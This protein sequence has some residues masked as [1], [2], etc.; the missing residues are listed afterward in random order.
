MPKRT[1]RNTG[2]KPRPKDFV[3]FVMIT[4]FS[5]ADKLRRIAQAL[6]LK[7]D[8]NLDL[9][10][11]DYSGYLHGNNSPAGVPEAVHGSAA[12]ILNDIVA[13]FPG[14]Y[15]TIKNGVLLIARDQ[16]VKLTP[17][18]T[19]AGPRMLE[20]IKTPGKEK[21]L[22]LEAL[23]KDLDEQKFR[24]KPYVWTGFRDALNEW[25][26]GPVKK[27]ET[28]AD[29]IRCRIEIT[30]HKFG[31]PRR[32]CECPSISPRNAVRKVL[33]LASVKWLKANPSS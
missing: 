18:D 14:L 25:N 16:S 6:G 28:F 30:M 15:W 13:K 11:G 5:H 32:G 29:A 21:K 7:I 3:S 10:K 24:F 19:F 26:K 27:V 33:R 2:A 23:A 12:T 31:C 4:P 1:R 22:K 8:P 17:F 9:M 20:V